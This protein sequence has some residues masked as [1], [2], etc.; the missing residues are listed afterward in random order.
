MNKPPNKIDNAE[1][2]Y[3]AWSGDEP[4]GV[5]HYT[6]GTVATEIF[7]LAICRYKGSDSVYRLSCDKNW[8]TEQDSDYAS[9]EDAMKYLP[10]QYKNV[11]VNWIPLEK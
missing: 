11:P 3:W 4:F 9:I 10:E 2:L 7:G 8:E 6:D 5:L 1:V